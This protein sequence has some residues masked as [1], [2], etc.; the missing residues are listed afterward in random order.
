MSNKWN[1]R[2][3]KDFSHYKLLTSESNACGTSKN[4]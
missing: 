1:M 2:A 3:K 4:R